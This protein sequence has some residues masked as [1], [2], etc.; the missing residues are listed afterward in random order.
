MRGHEPPALWR[1]PEVAAGS[2]GGQIRKQRPNPAAQLWSIL[3]L[4]ARHQKLVS[5]KTIEHLT[6]ITR[7]FLGPFLG[8]IQ[9]YCIDEGLPP[10]TV[11]LVEEATGRPAYGFTATKNVLSAQNRVFVFDWFSKAVPSPEVFEKISN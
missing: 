9:K 4:S 3:V 10:L 1:Q 8:P 7:A 2:N 11:I 6:G 5:Y